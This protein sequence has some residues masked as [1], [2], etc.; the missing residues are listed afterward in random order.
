MHGRLNNSWHRRQ[1]LCELGQ[2]NEAE[3]S[4][5]GWLLVAYNRKLTNAKNMMLGSAEL[6]D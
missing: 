5:Y 4:H 3:S 6:R 2:G 1:S